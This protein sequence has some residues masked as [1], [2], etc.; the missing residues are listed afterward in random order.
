MSR[1]KRGLKILSVKVQN[2]VYQK[3]KTTYKDV[4]NE[5][6]NQLRNNAD[7]KNLIGI[8]DIDDGDDN[9]EPPEETSFNSFSNKKKSG[10]SSQQKKNQMEKWVKNVRRRVYDALNVLYASGV[11]KKDDKKQ[12]S[13]DLKARELIE[14]R[15]R[16]MREEEEE[17]S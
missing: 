16:E 7:M 11:L 15:K 17:M 1:K 8:G 9:D 4:A 6:I 14:Q 10:K 3:Q 5:L 12:V 13:C 2:L